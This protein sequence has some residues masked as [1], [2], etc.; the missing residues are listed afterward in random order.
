MSQAIHT[1][2]SAQTTLRPL[3]VDLD[4]T[5][6]KSDTLVDSLLVLARRRPSLLLALPGKLM[7]GKAVFK[8]FV[9]ESIS[10][11]VV[12]LPYNRKLLTFLEDQHRL[13][14]EIYLATGANI[15][16]ARRV[17]KHLGIFKGVLGSDGDLNLSGSNKLDRLRS[18]LGPREFD[19]IGN[20]SV[21]L[22]LLSHSTQPMVANSSI[23]LRVRMRSRKIRPAMEFEERNHPAAALIRAMRPHQWVKNLLVLAPLL[24]AH[25]ISRSNFLSGVLAFCSFSLAA[26]GTYIVNDLLDTETDRHH[27]DKRRRPFAAGD[28]SLLAG[29]GAAI[30][31]FALALALTRGLPATFS[32]W[33][34][35]YVVAT[36]AY[37][38]V[39]KR[40]PIVDVLILSGLYTLRLLAG[41]A[42]TQTHISNW[43]GGFSIFLFFSLAIAKRFAELENL[44]AS[45]S[46]PKNGR[47]YHLSDIEQLRVFGTASAFASVVIF[48][49]YINGLDV[50]ALYRNP[51]LL[52]L[53]VPLMLLW[54]CRVWLLASR[55][56]LHED[57]VVFAITDG[58]SLAIGAGVIAVVLF[59]L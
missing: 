14:R 44:R 57:P 1:Q 8:A 3:C 34:L 9:T 58:M 43:L 28:L 51:S 33:L 40:I 4:G 5:L 56:Q 18:S 54:L 15:E 20:A 29:L 55:G 19:Y 36:L 46:I 16:L 11:D 45:D 27:A 39:L 21:D 2:E 13:G 25:I 6:V 47:G 42:A 41:G 7:R 52:W 53:I 31:L 49:N 37:S 50:A 12:H 10:L 26:S 35:L 24:L 22:P 32:A 48:A 30:L 59:A 17:A 38:T 23:V